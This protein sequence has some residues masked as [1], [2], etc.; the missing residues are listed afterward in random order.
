[1]KGKFRE[2]SGMQSAWNS[3]WPSDA[4]GDDLRGEP[5]KLAKQPYHE[6]LSANNCFCLTD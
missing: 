5:A 4:G 2:E 3:E 6:H 1:M